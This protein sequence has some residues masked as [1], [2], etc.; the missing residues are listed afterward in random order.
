MSDDNRQAY[1][2]GVRVVARARRGGAARDERE[3]RADFDERA[4]A[5]RRAAGGRC[6]WFS[7]APHGRG[8]ADSQGPKV[9]CAAAPFVMMMRNGE[10]HD[11]TLPGDAHL[12]R[13]GQPDR[14]SERWGRCDRVGDRGHRGGHLRAPRA[15]A[16][17]RVRGRHVSLRRPAP[18]RHSGGE[19]D[20]HRVRA[21]RSACHRGR[22]RSGGSSASTS[23]RGFACTRTSPTRRARRG[24]PR[25]PDCSRRIWDEAVAAAQIRL[26]GNDG[27][28]RPARDQRHDH[29]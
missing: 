21:D 16:G 12:F 7:A 6:S 20:R 5:R 1:L 26:D 14:P 19:R 25:R 2:V 3:L 17:F 15:A 18:S 24:S 10:S 13:V 28:G 23:T 8:S 9:A 11:R 29:P 27:A 4:G 22:T